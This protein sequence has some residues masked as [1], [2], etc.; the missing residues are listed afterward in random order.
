MYEK[1]FYR[2][3]LKENGLEYFTL[4]IKESD[5]YIGVDKVTPELRKRAE[6]RLAELRQDLEIYI[7][8]Y[9]L[10]EMTFKPITIKPGAPEIVRRMA[11]AAAQADVGPMASVAGCVAEMM[12]EELAGFSR[13]VIV[14]NGGD[15]F[16]KTARKRNIGI[17]A[18]QSRFS[19]RLALEITPEQTPLGICTSSGTIGHSVSLGKADVCLVTSAASALADAYASAIGNKVQTKADI[20]TA[21][22]VARTLPDLKGILLV[23]NNEMGIWGDL[24]LVK[25]EL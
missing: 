19:G 21:L 8:E 25:K 6:K 12:G 14:E 16:I 2:D 23:I 24:S 5:L 10:F 11:A 22:A 15:I 1:R 3:N 4:V 20:E 7:A 17:Y 18:G 9:P 13:E